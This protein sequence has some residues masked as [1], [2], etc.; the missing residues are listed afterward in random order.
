MARYSAKEIERMIL[1]SSTN[2]RFEK[3]KE[4]ANDADY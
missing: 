3:G 2:R 4:Y 1:D